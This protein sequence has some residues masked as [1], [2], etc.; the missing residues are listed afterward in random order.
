MGHV[1]RMSH[2]RIS[3]LGL[4]GVV[5]ETKLPLFLCSL[6]RHQLSETVAWRSGSPTDRWRGQYRRSTMSN[7]LAPAGR[8]SRDIERSRSSRKTGRAQ[9]TW[10]LQFGD[11]V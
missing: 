8:V 6:K 4:A 9:A 10:H 3:H 1:R 11:K 5:G 2:G 7:D